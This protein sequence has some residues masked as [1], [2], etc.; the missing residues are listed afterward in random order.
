MVMATRF[1]SIG[2]C[3]VAAILTALSGSPAFAE[4]ALESAAIQNGSAEL[5]IDAPSPSF[6]AEELALDETSIVELPEVAAALVDPI[7]APPDRPIGYDTLG[8]ATT[9]LPGDGDRF[10]WFSLES[11]AVLQS[12]SSGLVAGWGF[13]FLDGPLTVEM[14]PRLF[15]FTIGYQRREWIRPDFGW[16]FVFRVGAFSDFEGSARKGVRFPGHLVAL[17]RDGETTTWALGVDYLD[18]DDVSLLPV[19]GVVWTPNEAFRVDALFPRPRAAVRIMDTPSWIY[20]GGELGGGTW[21]IEREE[22]W[23]DNVTYSDLRLVLGVET[24]DEKGR[25]SGLELGYVFDRR[26]SYRSTLGDY[27][28][29]DGLM[30]RLTSRY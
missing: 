27:S 2:A 20:L 17:F 22:S 26:L 9:W 13:H 3:A 30:I 14:P 12:E 23:D 5:A 16:D 6:S 28:P 10:G 11:L 4:E 1:R 7:A 29:D 8:G 24:L 19:L 15:D 21:A 25:R 18:R